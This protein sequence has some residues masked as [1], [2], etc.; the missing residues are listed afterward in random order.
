VVHVNKHSRLTMDHSLALLVGTAIVSGVAGILGAR[1]VLHH[2]VRNA[3]LD[4]PNDRSSHDRPTPRG[5][6]VAIAATVIAITA[7]AA[8]TGILDYHIAAALTVGGVAIAA[9]GWADDRRPLSASLRIMVHLA[10]AVWAVGWIGGL[11]SLSFGTTA[12]GLGSA[13]AVIAVA[14]FVWA[15]N[16]YNFMDG[17]DGIAGTEATIAGA[18][19]A[20]LLLLHG[21][22][23]LAIVATAIAAA[24]AGFLH[25]NWP[26]ARIFM[27][28]AGSGFLGFTFAVLALASERTASVPLL[29]WLIILLV[30]VT[31]A[32]LT[33]LRRI[34]A[35]EKWHGAH[36]SHAYQRTVRSGFSHRRTTMIV[37]II[38]LFLSGCAIVG[39]RYPSMVPIALSLATCTTVALYILVERRFAMRRDR[40]EPRSSVATGV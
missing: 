1:V 39:D 27:G 23:G 21:N 22:T 20:L 34:L 2:A 26:P 6:G 5:G 14:G 29:V 32:T 31:D 7:A 11:P 8:L 3:I 24:S 25:W 38:D 4:I 17:I 10:A 13:G 28:D 35:R 15:T 18:T 19:G 16:L 40:I 36:R 12:I 37:A 30:F 33:L 9:V